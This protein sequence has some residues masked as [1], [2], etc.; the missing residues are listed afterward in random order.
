MFFEK[1]ERKFDLIYIDGD[2]RYDAVKS[3]WEN[4]EK[5]FN[6]FVLFDDY[7]LSTK[8]Q[9]DIECAKLID[10]ID[11][12]IIY[13]KELIIMDRRIFL[14]DRGYKDEAI[15]YGQVLLK[16]KEGDR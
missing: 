13:D 7:H 15:D 1:D 8:Q 6:K 9:K 16:R 5:V 11:N 4:S 14:D 2:H 3:D 10:S 12:D